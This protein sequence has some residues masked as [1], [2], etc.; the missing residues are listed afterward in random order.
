MPTWWL[1]AW[2]HD[3]Y[4]EY[5]SVAPHLSHPDLY[6][7]YRIL[8]YSTKCSLQKRTW[9]AYLTLWPMIDASILKVITFKLICRIEIHSITLRICPW[10]SLDHTNDEKATLVQVMAWCLGRQAITRANVYRGLYHHVASLCNSLLID[11]LLKRKEKQLWW[12]NSVDYCHLLHFIIRLLSWFFLQISAKNYIAISS[13]PGT[14]FIQ[15]RN[16]KETHN[17]IKQSLNLY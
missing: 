11:S 1:S 4:Q 3:C 8:S 13:S 5:K 9:A 15:H 17:V 6:N 14:A 12:N 2:Q 16:C 10:M 7:H